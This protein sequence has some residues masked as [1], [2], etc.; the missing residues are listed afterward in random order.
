MLASAARALRAAGHEVVT[1]REPGGTPVGDSVR[2]I[3]LQP[4]VPVDPLAEVL[5]VNASRAQLVRDVLAP[6]IDRGAVVLCDR[7]V[8]STLAYQGYG[9][10]LPLDVVRSVC[11]VAAGTCMPD[12]VLLVDVGPETSARR[13]VDRAQRA[14]RVESEDA[15]FHRRVREGYL[16]LASRDPR[17]MVIDGERSPEE[18]LD[19]AMASISAAIAT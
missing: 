2:A 9:R 8:H 5:L 11:D 6:A 14:D 7:Y 3:F 4:G 16:H 19:A 13:L 15:E 12:L 17:M 1:A 10:G 18:V